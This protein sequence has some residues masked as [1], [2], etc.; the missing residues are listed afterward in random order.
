MSSNIYAFILT[1][2][3]GFSTLIGTIIIFVK[4]NN[5]QKLITGSLS[6]AASIMICISITDLVPESL[7]LISNNN[8]N[9]VNCIICIFFILIG[10]SL[11]MLIN[12]YIP[13]NNN[14]S[15]NNKNLYKVGIISML[16]I[17]L[18]NIPEGIATYIATTNDISLGISLTLAIALHNIPEGI[19]ISIP[20]Y[21]AT[22][23]KYK[24]I[25]YT[26]VS[27]LS[28]PLGAVIT[29]LFLKQYI[30]TQI[31]GYIFA[32]IAGI[33]LHIS[34]YELLP[35]AKSYNNSK[36]VKLFFAIGTIFSIIYFVLF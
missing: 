8:T 11:S 5:Y 31:L 13:P 3:A 21:Y 24:A 17:I 2:L 29:Y 7:S 12:Y 33:M 30:T 20:I 25:L 26:L 32:I 36:I 10:A 18:H 14:I 1:S 16:A 6:F 9:I 34:F 19:A 28:E 15:L 23:S 4:S 35:T 27:A 22:K